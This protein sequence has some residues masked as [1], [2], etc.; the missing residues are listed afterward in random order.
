MLTGKLS[1]PSFVTH[2][3]ASVFLPTAVNDVLCCFD[4]HQRRFTSV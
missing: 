3:S 2:F 4:L 1:A